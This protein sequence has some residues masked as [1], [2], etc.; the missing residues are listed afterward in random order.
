MDL[1]FEQINYDIKNI[2]ITNDTNNISIKMK[3]QNLFNRLD[4]NKGV[5]ENK[6]N[7]V[8]DEVETCN[9]NYLPVCG[10]DGV[11]YNNSCL[12]EKA[13]VE[14]NNNGACL[15]RPTKSIQIDCND[16]NPCTKD[17]E[18]NGVCSH[19]NQ[20]NG[21]ICKTGNVCYNGACI[22]QDK[23]IEN[24]ENEQNRRAGSSRRTGGVRK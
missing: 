7:V 20:D 13:N 18:N 5:T 15:T 6:D 2:H 24:Y 4:L 11:T 17:L 8:E 21:F 9:N 3:L 1:I 23:A 22:S 12:A 10:V 19:S 16:N 14:I